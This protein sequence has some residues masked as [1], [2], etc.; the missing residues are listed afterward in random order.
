MMS[1]CLFLQIL[2]ALELSGSLMLLETLISIMCREERH[3]YE[4][5]MQNTLAKFIKRYKQCN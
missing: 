2:T 5:E 4:E 3:V 1:I